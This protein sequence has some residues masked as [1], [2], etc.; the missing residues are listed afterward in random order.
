MH[1]VVIGKDKAGGAH[2]R[3]HRAAHLEFVA[4]RQGDIVYAG[5]LIEGGAMV[6]S[7]FVFD[8]PDGDALEAYLAADPYF[9]EGIFETVETYE[10]RWMVPEREPG[11]LRAEAERARA[12]S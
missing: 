8:L 1:F 5:P 2:R 4:G 3:R 6:G 9:A 7:L 11:F 10:S 12:A